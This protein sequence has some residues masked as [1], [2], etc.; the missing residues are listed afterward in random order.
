MPS[1]PNIIGLLTLLFSG[2]AHAATATQPMSRAGDSDGYAVK[3]PAVLLPTDTTPAWLNKMASPP[4]FLKQKEAE[5]SPVSAQEQ[6]NAK[7][8]AARYVPP[9][10]PN[11]MEVGINYY[12]VTNNFGNSFGQFANV[13][14]QSDPWNRWLFGVQHAQAFKDDGYAASIGNTH[15][16][17]EDWYSEAGASI[18]SP[19]NFLTRYRVDGSLSRRWL[20]NRNFI[21]TLGF[22]YDEAIR[23]YSDRTGRISFAYY[24]LNAWAVQAGFNLNVSNPGSVVAPSGFTALTYGFQG[25]YFLTGRIGLARE[26][27]QLFNTNVNNRFDSQTYGISWRQWIGQDWGFNLGSEMYRNPFYTRTGG[28]VSV[29]RE[30]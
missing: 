11:Y 6:A 28:T 1:T 3:E 9:V 10:V 29:F 19:A 27:Y 30:F 20:E 21:S 24:F 8:Q 15:V 4:V 16:F 18:G 2:T 7:P 12:N 17:N 23:G 14:Y 13:Q 26:A 5:P 22:T 25:K